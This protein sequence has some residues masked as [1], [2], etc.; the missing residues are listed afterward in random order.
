VPVSV[1]LEDEALGVSN[2][3]GE[4]QQQ[5]MCVSGRRGVQAAAQHAVYHALPF[6]GLTQGKAS[7]IGHPPPQ[8]P[9]WCE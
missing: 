9:P 4:P 8:T 7:L 2:P 5:K 6:S 1:S 3:G